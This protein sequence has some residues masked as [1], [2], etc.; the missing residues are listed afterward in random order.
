MF[1]RHAAKFGLPP[2]TSGYQLPAANR[3]DR[4]G[5]AG[6]QRLRR[7]RQSTVAALP[8][9]DRVNVTGSA[10]LGVVCGRQD[11]PVGEREPDR[12][13]DVDHG[14]AKF[15]PHPRPGVDHR[16]SKVRAGQVGADR[17]RP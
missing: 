3:V 17:P 12:L 8:T 1:L 2:T 15:R 10:G 9:A 6:S 11:Q 13:L 14:T 5:A 16:P 7:Y 4:C